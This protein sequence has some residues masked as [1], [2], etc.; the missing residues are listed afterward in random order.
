[1]NK[2]AR[3]RVTSL[4]KTTGLF[5]IKTHMSRTTAKHSPSGLFQLFATWLTQPTFALVTFAFLT[6]FI[7]TAN[8][9]EARS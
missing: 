5:A 2:P 7:G 4:L 3:V 1:M 6:Y 9:I 8:G